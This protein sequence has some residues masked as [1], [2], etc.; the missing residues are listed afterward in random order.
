[1]EADF[2][3]IFSILIPMM[4]GF[5]AVIYSTHSMVHNAVRSSSDSVNQ[6]I[7]DFRADVDRRFDEQ[8]KE[9]NR[10]FD[11]QKEDMNR[12]FSEVDGKFDDVSKRLDGQKEEIS[13]LSNRLNTYLDS[14]AIR[15]ITENATKSSRKKRIVEV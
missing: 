8:K 11:E 12:R 7:D 1:M 3:T 6:R 10:R 15:L 5:F 9:M 2:A 14:Y 4:F 13:L